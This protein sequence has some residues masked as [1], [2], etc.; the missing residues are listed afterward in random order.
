M[1]KYLFLF[2]AFITFISCNKKDEGEPIVTN[3][4]RPHIVSYFENDGLKS[5]M[6]YVYV[7]HKIAA[8]NDITPIEEGSFYYGY[9]YE[10][11]YQLP[12]ITLNLHI[13]YNENWNHFADIV[14]AYSN[15]RISQI[16]IYTGDL[17]LDQINESQIFTYDNN[18]LNLAI[19]MNNSGDGMKMTG[20][21]DYAYENQKLKRCN[22]YSHSNS[23]DWWVHRF[24]SYTYLQNKIEVSTIRQVD[25]MYFDQVVHTF[26]EDRLIHSKFYGRNINDE[27]EF[28]R[29]IFYMYD[30]EGYL[31][32]E[33][34]EKDGDVFIAKIEYE[35]GE[36]NLDLFFSP[37]NQINNIL[38][39]FNFQ[40][41]K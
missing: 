1:K 10:F 36:D 32:E 38:N 25:S 18:Q 13:S 28:S 29:E 31:I 15:S 23:D 17:G 16:D 30:T 12:K 33:R 40:F 11:N 9:K 39:P 4:K 6:E 5:K 7:D 24:Q 2:L 26:E 22:Y 37:E 41:D 35:L 34:T 21:R 3:S 14:Y 8:V 20:K 27:L 19:T